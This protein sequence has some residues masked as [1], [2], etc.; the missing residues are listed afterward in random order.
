MPISQ[1]PSRLSALCRNRLAQKCALIALAAW[2]LGANNPNNFAPDGYEDA[3]PDSG[4]WQ[5]A[6][7][8][9]PAS[10]QDADLM[11][12]YVGPTATQQFFVD[13]KSISITGDNVVRYTL[14]SKSASGAV[15]V[16]YEG[17][18]CETAQFKQFAYGGK[19][20]VW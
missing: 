13:A 12:F 1:K 6:A 16:S 5:E 14:I 2:S 3:Q 15:N 19:D 18:R 17:T 7:V 20:G 4:K 8:Q 11:P 10:P 9:L